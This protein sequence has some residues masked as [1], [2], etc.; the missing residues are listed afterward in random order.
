MPVIRQFLIVVC[1]ASLLAPDVATAGDGHKWVPR[2]VEVLP[3]DSLG[4]LAVRHNVTVGALRRWNPDKVGSSDLIK[5]GQKLLIMIRADL[6]DKP[7]VVKEEPIVGPPPPS[8]PFGET[9]RGFYQIRPGD[10][11]GKI[12]RR[13]DVTVAELMK[14]NKLGKDSTIQIGKLLKYEKYGP[15]PDPLSVGRPMEGVLRYGIHLGKGPGYRLRFPRNAFTTKSV[16]HTLQYC[17]SRMREKFRGTADILIGDISRPTG[18][19]FPPHVSH[20][21]GRDADVG[22]YLADNVQ[23]VTMHV[24]RPHDIDYTKTWALL[25]CMIE[26]DQVVRVFIDTKIQ[27]AM[28]KYLRKHKL[29][30]D[31][32][33]DRLFESF[34]AKGA[35]ALI[36][37]APKHDTHIHIRF[38]CDVGVENCHEEPGDTI[39]VF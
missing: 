39:F 15:R 16:K 6:V 37:H 17:T 35:T 3:G 27:R 26:T 12:A 23:N 28:V 8:I 2:R 11:L 19:R 20:Q 5:V 22:Y 33:L 36:R 18:G 31:P 4:K 7:P 9:W 24:V 38:A 14:W 25:R 29:V 1:L 10:N 34:G 21:S 13:L 32:T 30:A